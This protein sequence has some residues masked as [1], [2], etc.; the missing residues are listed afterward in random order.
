LGSL[1]AGRRP[2]DRKSRVN[3]DRKLVATPSL[4]GSGGVNEPSGSNRATQR[5]ATN[6]L[7][8]RGSPKGELRSSE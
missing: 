5:V 2:S 4:S 6:D 7:S 8:K 1:Q 3:P